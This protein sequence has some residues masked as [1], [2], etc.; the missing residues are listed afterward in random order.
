MR[1]FRKPE[2]ALPIPNENQALSVLGHAKIRRIKYIR[3][4]AIAKL[5]ASTHDFIPRAPIVSS[6]QT[7]DVFEYEDLRFDDF[8]NLAIGLEQASSRIRGAKNST[9]SPTGGRERLAR[10][11]ANYALDAGIGELCGIEAPHVLM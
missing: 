8:K 10:W 5:T 4:D 7:V 3:R 9:G 2:L 11:A 1:W 6:G